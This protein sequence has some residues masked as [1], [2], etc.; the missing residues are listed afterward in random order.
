LLD[1]IAIIEYRGLGERYPIRFVGDYVKNLGAEVN[2]DQGFML[3]LFIGRASKK[4]DLRFQYGYAQTETDAVL[5]AF[6]NDNTTIAT[7]YIQHTLAIDYV[8]LGNTT[9]NL[10]WYLH[11]DKLH[12]GSGSND[13]LSR[14]RLNAVVK[15]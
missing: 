3:D 8:V 11:K 15:F 6:S 9:L 4:N 13:F 1:A 10:T 12:V 5:A 7:N 14:L 2:E